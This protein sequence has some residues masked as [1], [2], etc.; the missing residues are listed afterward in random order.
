MTTTL[1]IQERR[2]LR[3]QAA[4][5]GRTVYTLYFTTTAGKTAAQAGVGKGTIL[6][7]PSGAEVMEVVKAE[8]RVKGPGGQDIL[9][10]ANTFKVTA[11]A[12]DTWES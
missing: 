11:E 12:P 1:G 10:P 6:T 2:E 7:D 3:V 5:P 9:L 4:V 8:G